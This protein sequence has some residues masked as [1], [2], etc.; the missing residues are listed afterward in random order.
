MCL[1]QTPAHAPRIV[2]YLKLL[3]W[4]HEMVSPYQIRMC[5][6]YIVNRK[7]TPKCFL[8]YLLQNP[9]DFDKIWH[10][11][12][13]VNLLHRN[14]NVLHFTCIVCLHYLVKLSIR[15]L[16]VNYSWN[17]EPKT[18]QNLFVISFTK[19]DRFWQSLVHIFLIKFT[20]VWCK[21][22]HLT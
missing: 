5:H 8:S 21:R 16:Q 9:T 11:L 18:H 14:V 15:V 10:I 4:P 20:I 12:S 3:V 19:W 13:W 2:D 1:F 22:S 17:C 6:T 7:I